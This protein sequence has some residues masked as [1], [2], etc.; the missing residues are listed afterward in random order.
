SMWTSSFWRRAWPRPSRPRLHPRT[1][2]SLPNR[3]RTPTSLRL[4][5]LHLRSDKPHTHDNQVDL[6]FLFS[7]FLFLLLFLLLPISPFSILEVHSFLR[8]LFFVLSPFE[9]RVS[10]REKKN[11][12][13]TGLEQRQ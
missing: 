4:R 6:V 12:G 1:R 7:L 10:E 9:K 8:S 5:M 3:H 2:S 13:G 11:Y